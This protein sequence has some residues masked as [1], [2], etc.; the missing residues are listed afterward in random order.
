MAEIVRVLRVLEYVGP[1]DW[2]ED[3]INRRGIKGKVI[4]K[5]KNAYIAEAILG[6]TAELV[7]NLVVTQRNLRS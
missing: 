5:E 4:L 3:A 7:E 2:I 1:R 6:E